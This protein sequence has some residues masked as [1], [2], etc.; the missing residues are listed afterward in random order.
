MSYA[1]TDVTIPNLSS[2]LNAVAPIDAMASA[3]AALLA[4][5]V[6]VTL[7]DGSAAWVSCVQQDN[8]ETPFIEFSAVAIAGDASGVRTRASGQP[9]HTAFMHSVSPDVVATIGVDAVRKDLML[10]ALGETPVYPENWAAMT[11]RSIRTA[12]L[13]AAQVA[14]TPTDVL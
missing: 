7:D 3:V 11:D 1:K 4:A 12:I 2:A 14:A 8:P 9:V 10:L 6:T 13:V 5:G